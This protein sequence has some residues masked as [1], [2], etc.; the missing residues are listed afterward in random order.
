MIQAQ[1]AR[2]RFDELVS[3][4]DAGAAGAEA[5]L[6]DANR[7]LVQRYFDMWNTGDGSVA[8]AI[9]G[10]TYLDHAHP[11]VIG[12]AALRSLVPRY[13]AAN[14]GASMT[15]EIA[16]ANGEFVA[17]R[18]RIERTVAGEMTTSDGIAVFRAAAGKLA[19]QWSSYPEADDDMDSAPRSSARS[20]RDGW[21]SFRA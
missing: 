3:T 5:G 4:A 6:A 21:L 16:A 12:P 18:N 11:E 13:R 8:D 19:E 17:I 14:P 15:I 1:S 7:A 9:L 20:T 2:E 10:Q